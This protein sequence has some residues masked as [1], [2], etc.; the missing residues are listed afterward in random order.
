MLN[1][2]GFKRPTYTELVEGLEDQ[3]RTQ[4][5]ET[6]NT[7]PL[8]VWGIVIR[9]FAFYLSV[10][11]ENA[12][13]TY[14]SAY[15]DTATGVSLSRLGPFVGISRQP[16]QQSGGV[17]IISGTPGYTIEAGR[18]FQTESGIQF[19]VVEDSVIASNGS[20]TV[21]IESVLTGPE[22]NVAANTITS[23]LNPDASI[24]AVTNPVAIAGGRNAETDQEFRSRFQQSVANN[25]GG[26][27]DSI[28]AAVRNVSGVRAVTV[29][30]N[31]TM[32]T[33]SAGR[34]PKSYQTYVLGGVDADIARAIFSK[35]PAGIQSFGNINLTVK[36]MSGNNQPVAFSRAMN[37][38]IQASFT[39]TTNNT[40]PAD[41]DEQVKQALIN[42]VGGEYNG[43]YFS[44]LTMGDDVVYTKLINAIY[45][46]PGIEDVSLTVGR[47]GGTMS[48][49]NV[50]ISSFEVAQL[51]DDNITVVV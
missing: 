51:S 15:R 41:G 47:L 10:V 18:I 45:D 43:S 29:V 32:Q 19:E 21:P 46:V 33:D 7:S 30:Q 4:Y 50:A 27:V 17:L 31:T 16:E 40:F 11:W 37:V 8:S 20:V 24:T 38:N 3:W 34:P 28:E 35:G 42:Y 48:A 26:T 5:G 9:I 44:G 49:G 36:D 6:V 13:D 22:N 1:E 23:P 39:L 12:E 2:N 25:G 14:N